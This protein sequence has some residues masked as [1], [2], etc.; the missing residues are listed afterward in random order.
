MFYF[1]KN[2]VKRVIVRKNVMND[3]WDGRGDGEWHLRIMA[4]E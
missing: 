2:W 4:F 1:L 3:E